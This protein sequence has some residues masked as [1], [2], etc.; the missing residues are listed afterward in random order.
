MTIA[1]LSWDNS[2]PIA[3]LAILRPPAVH[4]PAFL[5]TP[6]LRSGFGRPGRWLGAH[7]RR[8]HALGLAQDTVRRHFSPAPRLGRRLRA[9]LLSMPG[10]GWTLERLGLRLEF[11]TGPDGGWRGT[12]VFTVLLPMTAVGMPALAV[13]L[14]DA[15]HPDLARWRVLPAA[16]HPGVAGATPIPVAIEPDIAPRGRQAAVFDQGS[17]GCRMD[18]DGGRRIVARAVVIRRHHRAPPQ[19][20]GSEPKGQAGTG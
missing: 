15:R 13:A 5:A 18:G 20:G 17:R 8:R 1:F 16:R 9:P 4:A 11:A 2:A 10:F 12:A 19:S 14:P 6:A 7:D 3:W